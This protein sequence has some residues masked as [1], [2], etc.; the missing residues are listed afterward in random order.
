MHAATRWVKRIRRGD[1]LLGLGICRWG[2]DWFGGDG[3]RGR[4]DLPGCWRGG[5]DA[6]AW[7]EMNGHPSTIE[8]AIG[9]GEESTYARKHG[10]GG[11][12]KFVPG[13]HP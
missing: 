4:I 1:G 6:C 5:G 7:W 8:T 12:E 13:L 9:V 2:R 3:G 10:K 11:E